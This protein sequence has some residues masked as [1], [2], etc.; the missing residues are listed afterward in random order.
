MSWYD[1]KLPVWYDAKVKL[2]QWSK[3]VRSCAVQRKSVP[4]A[5][6]PSQDACDPKE[7]KKDDRGQRRESLLGD[8]QPAKSFNVDVFFKSLSS[9]PCVVLPY[10]SSAR[11]RTS[12]LLATELRRM[13]V[14]IRWEDLNETG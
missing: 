6:Q 8:L 10:F 4:V 1:V 12:E 2:M 7:K 5:L 14:R 9:P 11:P 13:G 3:D